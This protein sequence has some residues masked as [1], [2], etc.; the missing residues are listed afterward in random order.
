MLDQQD[1]NSIYI[2]LIDHIKPLIISNHI[3]I[4]C[5]VTSTHEGNALMHRSAG[6]LFLL[7][8]GGGGTVSNS[9]GITRHDPVTRVSDAHFLPVLDFA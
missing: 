2:D 4:S 6:T 3:Q 1:L 8:G 5:V 7:W 9:A